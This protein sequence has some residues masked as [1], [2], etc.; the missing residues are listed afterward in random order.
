[1]PLSEGGWGLG[2]S[3]G[4]LVFG[5]GLAVLAILYFTTKVVA[6][7]A[8]LGGVHPHPP[9]WRDGRGLP[10]QAARQGRSCDEPADRL[11]GAC[12]SSSSLLILVL[13]QRPGSHPGQ[14]EAS[15]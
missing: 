15:A 3:G 9:A 2:Y 14:A 5:A 13:P 4:A 11:R 1:M 7:G 10:R 12:A 8:V 6:R